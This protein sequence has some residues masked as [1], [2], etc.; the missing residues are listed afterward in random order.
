V[1]VE[2]GILRPLLDAARAKLRLPDDPDERKAALVN[3]LPER[4]AFSNALAQLI[5]V[6]SPKP[7]SPDLGQ[8]FQCVLYPGP[9]PNSPRPRNRN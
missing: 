6:E 3:P 2:R 9:R 4:E 7:P 1:V 8:L 5:L